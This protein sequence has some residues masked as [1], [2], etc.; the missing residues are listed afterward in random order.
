M[1]LI[2]TIPQSFPGRSFLVSLVFGVVAISLF[3]QGLTM[4]PVLRYLGLLDKDTAHADYELA[5]ARSI[6]ARDAL[7]EIDRLHSQGFLTSEPYRTLQTWCRDRLQKAENEAN[8]QTGAVQNDE[9]I[10]EGL[11][12]LAVIER[13]SYRRAARLGLISESTSTTLDQGVLKLLHKLDIMQELDG[14]ETNAALA[15]IIGEP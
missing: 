7:A 1:V 13:D 9:Q 5:H 15:E 4:K 14:D 10:L 8:Q 3:L 2:L 11:R 12:H 6:A